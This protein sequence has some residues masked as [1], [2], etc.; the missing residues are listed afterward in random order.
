M[1]D[2]HEDTDVMRSLVPEMVWG[3]YREIVITYSV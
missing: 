2:I 3:K 1:V